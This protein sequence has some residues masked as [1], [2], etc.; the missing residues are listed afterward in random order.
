MI[1]YRPMMKKFSQKI[2]G[3]VEN[4]KA[5]LMLLINKINSKN[6]YK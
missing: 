2:E 6:I 5:S 1:K 3:G 4:N